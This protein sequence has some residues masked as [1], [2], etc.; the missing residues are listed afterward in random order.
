MKT[1]ISENTPIRTVQT[2]I[3]EAKA[4]GWRVV[5]RP[6]PA[7]AKVID[8]AEAKRAAEE[9]RQRMCVSPEVA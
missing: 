8:L 5:H 1:Q 2:I 6:D 7:K 9:R 3:D 4:M